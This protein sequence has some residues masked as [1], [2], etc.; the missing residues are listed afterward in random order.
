VLDYLTASYTIDGKKLYVSC[1]IGI[2]IYPDHGV[3]S[4][5]LLRSADTAMY[6][7]KEAGKKRFVFFE[8]EMKALSM[9][10]MSIE[11]GLRIALERD[12][13]EIVFQPKV[14]MQSKAILGAEVLLRW[15][16]PTLGKVSPAVFIP[17]AEKSGLMTE[18][19]KKVIDKTFIAMRELMTEGF[20]VPSIALNISAVQ[21]KDTRFETCILDKLELYNIPKDKIIVEITES[22]L[23][24]NTSDVKKILDN[25]HAQG[26]RISIDD[27][28]T[29]YSS[30]SYLKK[31]PLSELKI[32][33]SFIDDIESSSDDYH[34]THA[35]ID[36][37]DALGLDVIA[38]GVEN[39]EQRS[40]LSSL[41]CHKAQGYYFYHPLSFKDF[42]KLL[43]KAKLN[44]K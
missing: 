24:D 36:I 12:L 13:F 3:D 26:I 11:S 38:E 28:G 17:I 22:V 18:I 31:Y 34:I 29:G 35:I 32:D 1:S 6:K 39:E 41:G 23:M 14:D 40:I 25:F 43:K 15:N 9:Q 42:K 37:A 21:F 19:G 20:D 27:F 8:E 10:R 30:L 16:D 5:A 44:E 2:S 7:A 33:R 4:S